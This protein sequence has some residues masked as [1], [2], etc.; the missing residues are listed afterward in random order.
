MTN[1]LITFRKEHLDLLPEDPKYPRERIALQAEC[2][3]AF[4]LVSDGKIIGCAG[5]GQ[6][7]PFCGECWMVVPEEQISKHRKL[8]LK[9]VLGV[10][11][12]MKPFYPRLQMSVRMDFDKAHVFAEHLGFVKEGVMRK[13]GGDV[14]HALYARVD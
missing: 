13:Y 7:T 2:G 14:D 5:I 3:V 6:I 10:I 8:V 11:D 4:T 1:E 9:T 12:L